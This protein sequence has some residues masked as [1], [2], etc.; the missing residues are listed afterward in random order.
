MKAKNSKT[1]IHKLAHLVI[2]LA[3]YTPFCVVF[4]ILLYLLLVPCDLANLGYMYYPTCQSDMTFY[5][6]PLEYTAGLV[7]SIGSPFL[8]AWILLH[9]FGHCVLEY[10][11]LTTI[12]C[13]SLINC[14]NLYFTVYINNCSDQFS[15]CVKMFKQ[16]QMLI[17]RY[18]SIHRGPLTVACITLCS[19]VFIISFYAVCAMSQQL[20]FPQIFLFSCLS[21]DGVLVILWVD[22]IFKCGVI[23]ASKQVLRNVRMHSAGSVVVTKHLRLHRKHIRSWPV[24]KI[25]MGSI[26]YY[27]EKTAL[28]LLDFNINQVVS[29]LML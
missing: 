18:N 26:N 12:H 25:N 10:T 2:I 14:I 11:M 21:M 7:V 5:K 23:I 13:Y 24:L 29:L 17:Q 15:K 8:L 22:G 27:D 16:L 4:A 9:T 3:T 19:F 1:L 6:F 28:V 20:L